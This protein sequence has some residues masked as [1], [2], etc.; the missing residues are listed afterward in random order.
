MRAHAKCRRLMSPQFESLEGKSLLSAG[1]AMQYVAPGQAAAPIVGQ[2]A[3]FRGTL[4]GS[5]SDRS[6]DGISHVVSFKTAGTLMGPGSTHLSGTLFSRGNS[7]PGQLLGQLLLRNSGGSMTVNVYRSATAG[8]FT[9]TVIRA[10]SRHPLSRGD[11]QPAD[12]HVLGLQRPLLLPPAGMDEIHPGLTILR[13]RWGPLDH[14]G[15]MGSVHFLLPKNELT[16][17]DLGSVHFSLPKNE[18]TPQLTSGN[19]RGAVTFAKS[20]KPGFSARFAHEAGASFGSRPMV[21]LSTSR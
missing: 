16:P 8:T 18:P 12:R 7:R 20:R 21:P 3:S 14:R 9:D 10:G 17:T 13:V 2:A 6:V 5:D 15:L 4:A 19:P 11:W 1:P